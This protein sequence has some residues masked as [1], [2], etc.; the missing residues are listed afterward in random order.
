MC[1]TEHFRVSFLKRD[2]LLIH[3]PPS[4]QRGMS[5]GQRQAGSMPNK[6]QSTAGRYHITNHP[7]LMGWLAAILWTYNGYSH[8]LEP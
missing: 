7:K 3:T 2:Q 4:S 6:G 8:Y 5:G 1:Y